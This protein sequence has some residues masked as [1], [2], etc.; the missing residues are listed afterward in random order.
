MAESNYDLTLSRMPREFLKYDQRRMRRFCA[1]EDHEFLYLRFL[2]RVYRASREVG[3]IEW[4]QDEKTWQRAGFLDGMT[5]YDLLCCAKDEARL[6]GRFCKAENLPGT[7]HGANPAKG[8]YDGFARDC[9]KD[10]AALKDACLALGGREFPAGEVA[11]QIPLFDFLPV[12]V[13]FWA[14][15]EDFPPEFKLMWDENSLLFLRYETICYASNF[16]VSR[17]QTNMGIPAP[18]IF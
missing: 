17:L 12:V 3:T 2:D 7:A 15:D 10:P 6:S 14:S 1:R 9:D 5:L 13:Q 8:A 4:T 18:E 11:Y 16:L